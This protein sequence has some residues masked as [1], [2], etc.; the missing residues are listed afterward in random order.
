MTTALITT[1]DRC[2]KQLAAKPTPRPTAIQ[3]TQYAGISSQA[4]PV[5]PKPYDLCHACS[6]AFENWLG[7][8]TSSS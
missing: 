2:T 3:V 5:P 1:C 7:A 8:Q 6:A 4:S